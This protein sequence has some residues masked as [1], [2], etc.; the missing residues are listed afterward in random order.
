MEKTA[1]TIHSQKKKFIYSPHALSNNL[2]N[3]KIYGFD[4]VYLQP[5]TFRLKLTDTEKRLHLAFLRAQV[6]GFGINIEID[7]YSPHQMA[8]G[9]QNFAKYA[10][11][12][13]RYGLPGRSLI[14]YQGNEMV[15]RMG[16]YKLSPYQEGYQLLNRVFK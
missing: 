15:Y 8:N 11:M 5:N 2:E 13:E 10:E 4:G 6:H 14:F 9:V 12:A 3:W 1:N 16:T 7:T